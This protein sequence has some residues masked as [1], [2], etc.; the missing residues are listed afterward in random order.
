MEGKM[1]R[2]DD[3]MDLDARRRGTHADAPSGPRTIV[4]RNSGLVERLR[5]QETGA[6]EDLVDEYGDRVYRLALRITGNTADAEEVAQ[7]ALWAASR[8]IDTF[9]EA[10]AFGSWLYRIAANAA[11]QKLRGRRAARNELSWDALPEPFDQKA[12][13]G[14]VAL[15]WSGR[16]KDPA[17]QAELREVLS[18]A[19]DALPAEFRA[20]L[21]LRDV[22]GLTTLQVAATL[23]VKIATIKSRVHRARLLL[24][25][26]LGQ[27]M[28]GVTE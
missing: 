18:S 9:R 16:A 17:I 6:V 22:E 14:E 3:V 7:D 15:D 11:Y 10:A 24:R 20:P 19:I 8:N 4:D 21:V 2:N 1:R 12:H 5:R 25:K 13:Y 26:R 23:D 28:M 27:Y